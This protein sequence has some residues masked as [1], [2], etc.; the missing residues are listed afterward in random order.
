MEKTDILIVGAGPVGLYLASLLEKSGLTVR[1]LEEHDSIGRPN[2]CS[3]LVSRNLDLFVRPR[4][5]WI[6]HEVSGSIIRAGSSSVLLK[7]PR[8]AAYVIDRSRFDAFLAE[9]LESEI[10]LGVR[11]EG[12]SAGEEGASHLQGVTVKTSK[13]VF[14]AN[15]LMGCDGGN[16]LV[17]RHFHSR[18]KKLLMGVIGITREENYSKDV[19]IFLEKDLAR[20]GFF[21]KIP[22]GLTT[23]YGMF[24]SRADFLALESFFSIKPVGR[25]AG[26]IPLGPGKTFFERTL[27]VGDAAGMSKPWSGGGLI[28]GLTAARIAAR[29]VREAFQENDF[30]E[31]F[32]ARYESGWKKAFGRQIQAGMLGRRVFE[33]MGNFE[34]ETTLKCMRIFNPLISGLD[35]DFLVR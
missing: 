1:L 8:T 29:T 25:R 15:M 4:S 5:E 22:R 28:Y 21:W 16:S 6:E 26:L 12:V 11:V 7:K 3:G 31:N 33:K 9:S 34:V 35:M 23:E 18:P 24:S 10:R 32:L 13:G 17:A 14:K 2:H 27:L 20:D 30:S 19:E